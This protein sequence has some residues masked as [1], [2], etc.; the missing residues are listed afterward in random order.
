M[1]DHLRATIRAAVAD[2]LLEAAIA[3]KRVYVTRRTPLAAELLPAILVYAMTEDARPETLSGPRWLS[4]DLD[5]VIEG[6]AQDNASIDATLDKLAQGIE[7]A[8]GAAMANS[9]SPLRQLVRGGDLVRTQIA[10]GAPQKPDE[11]GTG[12]IVLTYRVNY[13]TRSSDPTTNS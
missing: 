3:G 6:V 5:L 4:R 9:Q 7:T 8:L 12:H 10:L 2:I 13:R 11:A 1:A